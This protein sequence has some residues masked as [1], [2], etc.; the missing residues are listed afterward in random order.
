MA[1]E[2]L[3]VDSAVFSDFAAPLQD[4]SCGPGADTEFL[5]SDTG[6]ILKIFSCSELCILV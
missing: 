3:I 6:R 2:R 5:A 4:L 1:V